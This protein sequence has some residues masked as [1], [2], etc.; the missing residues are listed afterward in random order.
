VTWRPVVAP[1][2]LFRAVARL[3]NKLAQASKRKTQ[4]SLK[5]GALK[6]HSLRPCKALC[7]AGGGVLPIPATLGVPCA[8]SG[9]CAAAIGVAVN[10]GSALVGLRL[11]VPDQS[12][13]LYRHRGRRGRSHHRHRS[14][15]RER[16]RCQFG[17]RASAEPMFKAELRAS[18]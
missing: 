1:Q 3:G 5:S 12:R 4:P 8:S 2:Q 11:I 16:L 17:C 7:A 15:A 14:C 9:S 6:P 10:T 13:A 18:S